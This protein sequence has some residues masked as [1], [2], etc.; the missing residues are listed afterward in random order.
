M[1]L[2]LDVKP[3]ILRGLYAADPLQLRG[4]SAC[5]SLYTSFPPSS[6]PNS[7]HLIN[8]AAV[9]TH[10]E[11]QNQKFRPR[12]L[13]KSSF[14]PHVHFLRSGCTGTSHSAIHYQ[15]SLHSTEA[16]RRE[17]PGATAPLQTADE[18]L[19]G[20]RTF[21]SPTPRSILFSQI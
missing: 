10:G 1:L 12:I 4:R 8:I 19:W 5:F 18:D 20:L 9:N 7:T 14:R 3:E 6:P 15:L 11:N 2:M 17:Q 16:V 13:P 21:L